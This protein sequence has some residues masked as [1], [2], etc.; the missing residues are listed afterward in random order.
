VVE[1]E[2][3]EEKMEGKGGLGGE[4][5]VESEEDL[6]VFGAGSCG[7]VSDF[8]SVEEA[9]GYNVEDLAGFGAEDAGEVGG[10]SAGEGGGGRGPGVGDP[11]AAGHG[12]KATFPG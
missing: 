9:A 12:R 4:L 6:G 5:F 8:G 1:L 7:D 10:L 2:D 3:G 11:A